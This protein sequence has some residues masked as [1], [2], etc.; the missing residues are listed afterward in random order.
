MKS[1]D[2]C[3]QTQIDA[4]NRLT[5]GRGLPEGPDLVLPRV[6]PKKT[7]YKSQI[8]KS[9]HKEKNQKV[10]RTCLRCGTPFWATDKTTRL[11]SASCKTDEGG[12]GPM[13]SPGGQV[14][15]R[16]YT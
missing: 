14:G 2:L 7:L 5:D 16:R 10:A 9:P 8:C 11:C 15:T 12:L 1:T 4:L 13:G 3:I 6:I